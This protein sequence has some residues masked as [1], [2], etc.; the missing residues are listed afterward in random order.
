MIIFGID[1]GTTTLRATAVRLAIGA[2]G[3]KETVAIGDPL[4]QLTPMTNHELEES[5]I[6]ASLEKWS[7]TL[8]SPDLGTLLFTGEAQR[9]HNAVAL[10]QRLS[11]KWRG[12]FSAQL[13]PNHETLV[14]AYGAQAVSLSARRLGWPVVHF[15]VGGGTTNVAWIEN[16]EI[17]DTACFDLGARK[18]I[19]SSLEQKI[20]KRTPQ[21]E[22]LEEVA[23]YSQRLDKLTPDIATTLAHTISELIFSFSETD[24]RF[25]ILPW[26]KSR[27]I[28]AAKTLSFSGGVV[29]CLNETGFPYGD[30]G[31]QLGRSLVE[32]TRRLG[33]ELHLSPLSGRAT[34]YGVSAHGFQLSGN[35]LFHRGEIQTSSLPL[36]VASETQSELVPQSLA[37][38]LDFFRSEGLDEE[39]QRWAQWLH[40]NK[41][42]LCVF[43]LK[44]NLGKSFGYLLSKLVTTPNLLV[45]DEIELPSRWPLGVRPTVD[46]RRA[47]DYG[48][49]SVIIK[50]LHLF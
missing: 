6:V 11:E 49:F 31:T 45:L 28:E 17:I 19:L 18:W 10:G 44:A 48:R 41:P 36:F 33:K 21:G 2:F 5:A 29:E 15:D 22:W 39:T 23:G 20:I 30:I 25:V 16:G 37:I 50:S 26:K 9:A 27:H 47:P 35:S 43:I 8:P 7:S 12:L 40:K 3:R 46:I 38:A 1:I 13:D 4:C 32:K 34:A 42:K 24:P 14:A